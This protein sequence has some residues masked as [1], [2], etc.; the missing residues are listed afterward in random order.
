MKFGKQLQL[1]CYEPWRDYYLS[2][3]RLKRII[4][5][6]K[7]VK[8]SKV[9]EEV[10]QMIKIGG[11]DSLVG[12]ATLTNNIPVDSVTLSSTMVST[13]LDGT[14]SQPT[15]TISNNTNFD[16]SPAESTPLLHSATI[17]NNKK[18][19]N[20]NN[21]HNDNN[22][23]KN[24]DSNGGSGERIVNRRT[25]DLSLYSK[26]GHIE[27]SEENSSGEDFF[28]VLHEEL[29]KINGFFT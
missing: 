28:A 2:Y 3:S 24:P 22:N 11:G 13:D 8:D 29:D 14:S 18:S 4:K 17:N 7:F 16:I 23:N 20:N 5:R 10:K 12:L 6:I 19:N 25:S 15:A 26:T 21:K 9:A 27:E 1:G